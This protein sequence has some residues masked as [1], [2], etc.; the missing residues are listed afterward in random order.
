[1]ERKIRGSGLKTAQRPASQ[2]RPAARTSL[3]PLGRP[4]AAAHGH[5]RRERHGAGSRC[6]RS[7]GRPA[8]SSTGGETAPAR[9]PSGGGEDGAPVLRSLTGRREL[10]RRRGRL[11]PVGLDNDATARKK[12]W[13]AASS[14]QWRPGS[15]YLRKEHDEDEAPPLRSE[16]RGG[17]ELT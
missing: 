3:R 13:L 10:R 5:S 15:G 11:V 6:A 16:G 8:R 9:A 17:R 1:L 2:D 4:H 7:G 14:G 12:K